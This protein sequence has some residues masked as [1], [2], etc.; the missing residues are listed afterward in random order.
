MNF[1]KIGGLACALVCALSAPSFA[2]FQMLY[3]LRALS[4]R[5]R[6]ST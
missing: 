1:K 2:H 6:L 4:T 3:T 5:E